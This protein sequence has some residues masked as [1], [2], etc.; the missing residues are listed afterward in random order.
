GAG[1]RLPRCAP[2]IRANSWPRVGQMR[3]L[4]LAASPIT[5]PPHPLLGGKAKYAQRYLHPA[6][7]PRVLINQDPMLTPD[8]L[9]AFGKFACT[10]LTQSLMC[11]R[12]GPRLVHAHPI[13][14]AVGTSQD[15]CGV[16]ETFPAEDA[17]RHLAKR[18]G[19]YKSVIRS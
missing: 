11:N 10:A 1:R 15:T 3:R 8:T 14:N 2:P 9:A 17:K 18:P 6:H 12:I 19:S 13:P 16:G 5:C 4:A 7:E